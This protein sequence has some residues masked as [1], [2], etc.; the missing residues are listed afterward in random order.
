MGGYTE[1]KFLADGTDDD[2]HD[3]DDDDDDVGGDDSREWQAEAK[4]S[5]VLAA[6][7]RRVGYDDKAGAKGGW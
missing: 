6:T 3:E 5:G 7:S 2:D 4:S 1:R